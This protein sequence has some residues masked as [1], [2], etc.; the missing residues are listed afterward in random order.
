MLE[1]RR[2]ADPEGVPV[3]TALGTVYTDLGLPALA[4]AA[5]AR[6]AATRARRAE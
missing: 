4:R 6:A 2:A 3:N 5:R 1:L